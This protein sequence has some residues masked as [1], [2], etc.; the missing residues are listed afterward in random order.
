[1]ASVEVSTGQSAVSTDTNTWASTT[2]TA[3]VPITWNSGPN[4]VDGA[5]SAAATP[6]R[7]ERKFSNDSASGPATGPAPVARTF[8][9][10]TRVDGPGASGSKATCSGSGRTRTVPGSVS[11]TNWE[12]TWKLRAGGT[13]VMIT[14]GG[15]P[16][17]GSYA[18]KADAADPIM[19]TRAELAALGV[20]NSRF[21]LYLPVGLEELSHSPTGSGALDLSYETSAGNVTLMR[22]ESS[23]NGVAVSG[24]E[25]DFLQIYRVHSLTE[26]PMALAER[27]WTLRQLKESL[28]RLMMSLTLGVPFRFGFLLKDVPVPFTEIAAGG[29][30]A[31]F[32]VSTR[33][34]DGARGERGDVQRRY[35]RDLSVKASPS[36]ADAPEGRREHASRGRRTPPRG[37]LGV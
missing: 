17:T 31:Q 10:F 4:E 21:H 13:L 35:Q 23:G 18:A 29:V 28:S 22:L 27:P 32:H 15:A 3:A 1:M 20:T 8:T 30:V 34:A 16:G 25:P 24:D 36:S 11:G 5:T 6:H 14:P 12:A 2:P 9:G 26:N 37:R 19:I 33:V 7:I